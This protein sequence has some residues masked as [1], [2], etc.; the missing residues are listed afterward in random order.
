MRMRE[1]A[2]M[3]DAIDDFKWSN[4]D[5]VVSRRSVDMRPVRKAT[6]IRA[7]LE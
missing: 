2:G 6:S 3:S 5:S 1:N 7:G 4:D